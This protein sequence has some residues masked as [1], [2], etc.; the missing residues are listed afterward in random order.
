MKR[1]VFKI[2][3]VCLFVLLLYSP[4]YCLLVSLNLVRPQ[5]MKH[6]S[7]INELKFDEVYDYHDVDILFVGSSQTLMSFDTRIFSQYGLNTFNMGTVSET[8]MQTYF[9]LEHYLERLKPKMVVMTVTP[10]MTQNRGRESTLGFIASDFN[11]DNAFWDYTR[12][13]MTFYDQSIYVVNCFI[14]N[15][16]RNHFVD[17]RKSFT[18]RIDRELRPDELGFGYVKGGFVEAP[19]ECDTTQLG[20]HVSRNNTIIPMQFMFLMKIASLLGEHNVE[21][22][23]VEVPVISTLYKSYE[24]H[25]EFEKK[26]SS[27]GKYLNYNNLIGMNDY[28]D[29]RDAFH[30]NQ[31]GV[32]KFDSLF[33]EDLFKMGYFEK[34]II[35]KGKLENWV[36]VR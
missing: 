12:L 14:Y 20:S 4:V 23:F 8:P 2:I 6:S 33:M 5:P 18:F 27:L 7:W 19:N 30:L 24:H 9:L 35:K 34:P 15:Y 3:V 31:T 28:G 11:S 16:F 10:L 25:D 21:C 13:K 32:I 36:D 1:F 26:I 29:F 22:L 17:D